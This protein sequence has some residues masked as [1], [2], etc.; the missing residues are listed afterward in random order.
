MR[1]LAAL[2]IA[3][4]AAAAAALGL[5]TRAQ[6]SSTARFDVIFD[7]ARGLVAGQLVKVAGANAGTIENVVVT[8]DFKARI[9]A[10]IDS[11][12][13]PFRRD[14][15]C[16]IRPQG[17]IA[18][19]YVDCDPGTAGSPPL[20]ARGGHPPTVPVA[21]TTEPVSLL[22][23]FNTF[24]LPTRQRLMVVVDELGIGTSGRGQ[25]LNQI[26]LRANPT[27]S[28]AR[29][30]IGILARQRAELQTLVGATDRLAADG[31]AHT[32]TL[33]RFLDEAAALTALTA[34]H[35]SSI[36][37]AVARLP[38]LLAAAQP[39]LQ[40]LDAVAR[41]GTPLLN[42]LRAAAPSLDRL[43][44]D[45]H[46]FVK[47]AT[48]GLARLDAALGKA[49]PALRDTAPLLRTLRSYADRSLPSTKLMATVFE[50]LQ[51]HG[52]LENFI[53][54]AYYIASSLARFDGTSH[55]LSLLL[56]APDN[57]ACNNYSTKPVPACS[58]HYGSQPAYKPSAADLHALADYLVK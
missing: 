6:G 30:A 25:D 44:A 48:P 53:S 1:R 28:L 34:S 45:L 41:D 15:T 31:A 35:S 8:P 55:L 7:D 5:G 54:I 14:A 33:Q 46:P 42:Q 49:I 16:A 26:L 21:R 38:G 18:E 47:A 12:F 52:F 51:R 2:A 29:Q 9:E 32:A 50:N 11:R 57:G 27:L 17:L 58:A 40:Q 24:N 43:A 22:D 23:L 39:S 20:P 4:V 37:R 10:T 19:N 3:V 36:S 56:V 13:M